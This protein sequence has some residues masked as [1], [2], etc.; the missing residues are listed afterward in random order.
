MRFSIKKW[1]YNINQTILLNK[2]RTENLPRQ[3]HCNFWSEE[4]GT[5]KFFYYILI[6]TWGG[7]KQKAMALP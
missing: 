5:E 2:N 6:D 7:W 4:K 3:E 1:K